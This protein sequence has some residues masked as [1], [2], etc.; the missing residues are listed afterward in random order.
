[1]QKCIFWMLK[2]GFDKKSMNFCFIITPYYSYVLRSIPKSYSDID[3]SYFIL[4][5]YCSVIVMKQ[6]KTSNDRGFRV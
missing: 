3:K 2:F 4:I 6:E 5:I 1:M